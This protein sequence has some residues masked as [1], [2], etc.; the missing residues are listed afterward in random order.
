M[1][2]E[3]DQGDQERFA[4]ESGGV[5]AYRPYKLSPSQI[6]L[7]NGSLQR[8]KLLLRIKPAAARLNNL[9]AP[10]FEGGCDLLRGSVYSAAAGTAQDFLVHIYNGPFGLV[11]GRQQIGDGS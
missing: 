3:Q 7:D 10:P 8:F 4:V 9:A 2:S 11:A 6:L 5:Q 1:S